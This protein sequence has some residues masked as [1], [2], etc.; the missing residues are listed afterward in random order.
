MDLDFTA[1]SHI[2]PED[3][4]LDLMEVFNQEFCGIKFSLERVLNF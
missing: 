2:D 4:I 3:A 1:R